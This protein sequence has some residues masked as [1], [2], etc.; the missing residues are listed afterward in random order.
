MPSLVSHQLSIIKYVVLKKIFFFLCFDRLIWT[1]TRT[2]LDSDSNLF[3]L[4]LDSDSNLFGLGLVLDS[5]KVDLTTALIYTHTHIHI[6]I[7]THTYIFYIILFFDRYCICISFRP[8]NLPVILELVI[9]TSTFHFVQH[10]SNGPWNGLRAVPRL[11]VWSSQEVLCVGFKLKLDGLTSRRTILHS[12]LSSRML[13]TVAHRPPEMFW[14]LSDNATHPL[15]SE[16]RAA[17]TARLAQ[18]T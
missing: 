1:W 17:P 10:A 14:Q 6:Y 13:S 12:C 11:S 15:S 8:K 2:S 5:T 9:V 4:G 16:L 18:R 7:Y 3:G